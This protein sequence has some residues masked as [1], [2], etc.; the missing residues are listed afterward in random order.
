[1]TEP[2][3]PAM[4]SA[5]S[6]TST[7]RHKVPSGY[8]GGLFAVNFGVF[9]AA[10]TPV[11]VTLAFKIEHIS[12]SSEEATANLALVLAVGALCGLVA[13]PVAGWLSDRTTSK[14]GMRRPWILGGMLIGFAVLLVIGIATSIWVVLAAWCVVQ[15]ATNATVAAAS[16]TVPD[17]VPAARFGSVAGIVGVATPLGVLAGFAIV[18]LFA[19]D[20]PRFVVPGFI[21]TA[22]TIWFVIGLKDRVLIEKPPQRFTLVRFLGSFVFNPVKHPTSPE[23]GWRSSSSCSATEASVVTFRTI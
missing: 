16:A 1:M 4:L 5:E 20:V 21:A 13:N 8:I 12:A 3:L 22:L 23:P 19:G 14:W 10:T 15:A 6:A 9:P 7:P 18:N 2:P 17:Q 11:A